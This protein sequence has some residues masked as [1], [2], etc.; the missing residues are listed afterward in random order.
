MKQVQWHIVPCIVVTCSTEARPKV[1]VALGNV[2]LR[3]LTSYGSGKTTISHVQGYL[4]DGPYDGTHVIGTF[5]P[6]ALMQGL[7]GLSG[8][9]IWAIQRAI[10]IARHGFAREPV[11][12]IAYPS[13]E[14][15]QAFERGW[16]PDAQRLD[17]DIETPESGEL[18]EEDLAEEDDE[19]APRRDVSYTI[20]RAS[21]GYGGRA[22]SFPWQSPYKE[23]AARMLGRSV[24]AG[25]WN[26]DFDVP[27]LRAAGAPV[28]GRVYDYMKLWKHLQPNLPT[29]LKC[30]SLEFVTPFYWHTAEPW[31]HLSHGQPEFYNAC[32]AVALGKCGDGI[33]RDLRAKGQWDLM[34]RHVVDCYQVLTRMAANGLPYDKVRAAEFEQEL[35]TK[36]DE[37]HRTLQEVVPIE[38][39]RPKQKEGYKK[40]PTGD[41][42][43][44]SG[45]QLRTFHVLGKDMTKEEVAT[46]GLALVKRVRHLRR[47]PL[48]PGGTVQPGQPRRSGAGGRP[49]WCR[50]GHKVGTT[51]TKKALWTTTP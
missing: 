21:L 28:S 44:V 2:A 45:L 39:K 41:D 19:E 3:A 17:F 31:K 18:D 35:T 5:H 51:K 37:R 26:E 27:R 25:V 36:Y 32:D 29:K 13:L 16:A 40:P 24:R 49:I 6:S 1:F 20:I 9:A 33:E 50:H 22:V 30:R 11:D 48:L 15:M 10:D 47:E 46:C 23:V 8:V 43:R 14:D 7:Q 4:L 12:V 38:L 42:V 34:E